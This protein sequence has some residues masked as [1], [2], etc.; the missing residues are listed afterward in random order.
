M[1]VAS[2]V[3]AQRTDHGVPHA[4]SCRALGVSRVWFYKWRDRP[5]SA[6]PG[7]PGGLD[8]KVKAVFD[9]SGGTY[10]SP[11]VLDELRDAGEAGVEEDRGALH[12]PPGVGGS[13]RARD[14]AT[15]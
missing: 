4:I 3:A 6:S 11:R 12:G 15:G 9:A 10:G 1:T 8:A 7:P 2:F 13:A 14:G 5:P